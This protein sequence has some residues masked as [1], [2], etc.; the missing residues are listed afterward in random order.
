M[1]ARR[2]DRVAHR[3][4]HRH[5][6]VFDQGRQRTGLGRG[7]GVDPRRMDLE[8]VGRGIDLVQHHDHH[9]QRPC[10]RAYPG[11]R[12]DP[13]RGEQVAGPVGRGQRRIAHRRRHDHRSVEVEQQVEQEAGL[14]GGIGALRDDDPVGIE[15][16]DFRGQRMDLVERQRVTADPRHGLGRDLGNAWTGAARRRR[17]HR[18]PGPSASRP[19][20]RV[21]SRWCRRV[22]GYEC[23]VCPWCRAV[24]PSSAT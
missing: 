2:N 15:P 5:D 19:R 6:P 12:R 3:Q 17:G 22:P 8:H 1:P 23:G 24:M 4:R 21:G 20:R 9:A 7:E 13:H 11:I 16:A 18:R 10:M 14:F